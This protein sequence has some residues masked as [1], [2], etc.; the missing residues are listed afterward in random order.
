MTDIPEDTLLAFSA[1]LEKEAQRRHA[2]QVLRDR[3][4]IASVDA[5]KDELCAR[6]AE[7]VDEWEAHKFTPGEIPARRKAERL[8]V[9]L[10]NHVRRVEA[11]R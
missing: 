4:R 5:R 8:M 6:L 3:R 9:S 7:A 2:I 10:R 11:K 1:L